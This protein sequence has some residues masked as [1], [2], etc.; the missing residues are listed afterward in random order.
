[1]KLI[2][3]PTFLFIIA[4]LSTTSVFA[5][6]NI[7]GAQVINDNCAKCHNARAVHEFSVPEWKVIMPHMR[8]KAHLTGQETLAVIEFLELTSQTS[9]S[10]KQPILVTNNVPDGKKLF[11]QYGCQGC[12]SFK[13]SGGS[14]G[15]ELDHVIEAKGI[16]FFTQKLQ[17][18]QF[19]NS[20]SPM[21]K[22]PLNEEQIK[23][24]AD[25]LKL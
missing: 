24:L 16:S 7:S 13:G 5:T 8:V 19:N 9:Q 11:G 25:Y 23:A 4:V 22:M 14:V 6:E 3:Y 1:M 15:P 12:H 10:L 2:N 20:A 21:P 18:P 17:N